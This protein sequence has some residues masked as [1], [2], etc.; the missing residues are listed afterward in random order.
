MDDGLADQ[1]AVEGISMEAG[2]TAQVKRGLL[3]E[4]KLLSRQL[5]SMFR[6]ELIRPLG[7]HQF[8]QRVF[9]RD[10]PG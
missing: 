1:H 8:S 7:Q 2:K 4:R 9:D 3:I 6:N 5:L 10:F